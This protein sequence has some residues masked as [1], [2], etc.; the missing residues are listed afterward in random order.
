MGNNRKNIF[1]QECKVQ[2]YLG[3]MVDHKLKFSEHIDYIKQKVCKRIGAMYR[4]KKLLPL[5]FRKMFANALMLPQFDYLDIIYS[6]AGKTKLKEL[7]LLYRKVAKIALDVSKQESTLLVYKDMKWIPL[8]LRRQLHLSTY[9]FRIVNG[10]CPSNF[11]NKFQYISGGSRD[12]DNCNLYTQKSK[13]HKE[14]FYL[15]AKCWNILPKYLRTSDN[16]KLFSRQY[17]Q[18]LLNSILTDSNYQLEN[19][20]DYFYKIKPVESATIESSSMGNAISAVLE[21]VRNY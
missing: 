9:M 10:C 1:I 2:K 17:K 7:D 21:S 16:V 18:Q 6:R 4:S 19:A 13:S 11:V 8:H 14:F 15:G 20:F 5:K 12:G 3:I